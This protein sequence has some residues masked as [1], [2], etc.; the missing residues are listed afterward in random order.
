MADHRCGLEM[1]ERMIDRQG[2]SPPRQPAQ[3]PAS[4][5]FIFLAEPVLIRNNRKS[6]P[7]SPIQII[8]FKLFA[9]LLLALLL[10]VIVILAK[11]T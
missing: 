4:N 6:T 2:A 11:N 7:R 1:G 10:L 5:P 9:A 8:N 3:K